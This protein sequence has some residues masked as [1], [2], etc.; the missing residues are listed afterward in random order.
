SA[1]CLDVGYRRGL[2]VAASDYKH[3]RCSDLPRIQA[4]LKRGKGGI[5]PAVK[6]NHASDACFGN[7][8]SAFPRAFD[9]EIDWLFTKYRFSSRRRK[10]DEICMS[11]RTGRDDYCANRRITY[12]ILG[13]GSF[14][15]VL[16]RKFS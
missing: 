15:P 9:I 2:R 3:F 14:R 1:R 8:V 12:C 5:E 10:E 4:R 13:V 16:S 6:A 11:V 7:G